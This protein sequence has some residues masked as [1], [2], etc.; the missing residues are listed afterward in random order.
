MI[1]FI[2]TADGTEINLAIVSGNKILVKKRVAAK[3]R[4]SELLLAE[5]KKIILSL[6]KKPNNLKAIV[7]VSG[8]GPFSA[9]RIGIATANALTYSLD[10]PIV[11]LKQAEISKTKDL[12]VLISNS[13]KKAKRNYI[14]RPFYGAKP[15]I[16]LKKKEL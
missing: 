5:I 9:L 6:K 1:L 10:L 15:N 4:Q 11:G 16:T 13:A 7:V 12:G 8:P 2:N 3:Y 14:V